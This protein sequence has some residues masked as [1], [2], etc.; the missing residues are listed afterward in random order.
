[1]NFFKGFF[2]LISGV[3]ATDSD[4]DSAVKDEILDSEGN[5]RSDIESYILSE[6][7]RRRDERRD[8]ELQWQLNANFLYGNQRCDINIRSHTVEQYSD[9]CDGL[10]KE[11][12]NQI[13]PLAK[14]RAANLGKISYAMTVKPRTSEID[15]ISKAKVSTS[16]LRYKQST[17]DFSRFITSLIHWAEIT[18]T[19]FVLNWWD[20]RA[21]D[22]VG[23]ITTLEEDDY[24]QPAEKK[25][26]VF[27]GDVNYGMLTPF[28]V[29][30][31]TVYKETVEDQRSIIT[32]QVMSVEDIY[33]IYGIK[34]DGRAIETYALSPVEGAGGFGYVATVAK[35]TSHTVTDI[36]KVITYFERPGR[37]F[38]NGRMAILIGDEL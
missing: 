4:S 27:S 10:E 6:L 19:A 35:M 37:K 29:F 13:E 2:S 21:G 34:V 7:E 1:M 36:E 18:G 11:I 16:I 28:E 14:T 31:E 8:I 17:S 33:D 12:Y 25:E 32:E 20:T 23:E 5:T 30:P 24:G 26:A 15:D 22:M 3:A 9:P 38:P